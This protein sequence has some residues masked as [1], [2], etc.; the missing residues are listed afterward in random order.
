MLKHLLCGFLA[1]AGWCAA[2]VARADCGQSGALAQDPGAD[3][4]SG[5]QFVTRD[6]LAAAEASHAC[7][8]AALQRGDYPQALAWLRGGLAQLGEHYTRAAVLDDTS[9]KLTVGNHAADRGP[10]AGRPTAP[11]RSLPAH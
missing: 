1:C 11:S 10:L 8:S 3:S 5:P 4:L 2:T 6:R 7:A 9:V